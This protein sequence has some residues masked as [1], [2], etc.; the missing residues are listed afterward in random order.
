MAGV[1]GEVVVAG[2]R[3]FNAETGVIRQ[4]AGDQSV[5]RI[6]PFREAVDF[7]GHIRRSSE[8]AANGR[9]GRFP[10]GTV[11]HTDTR[12]SEAQARGSENIAPPDGSAQSIDEAQ[13]PGA[14]VEPNHS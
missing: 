4:V 10:R 3:L 13:C 7:V 9:A 2:T 11:E 1:S 12:I 6:Q 8:R 5:S 14:P